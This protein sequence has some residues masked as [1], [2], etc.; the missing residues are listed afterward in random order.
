[1]QARGV[2]EFFLRQPRAM[3]ELAQN[4]PKVLPGWLAASVHTANGL[5]PTTISLHAYSLPEREDESDGI[6]NLLGVR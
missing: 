6:D 4:R 5:P 3:S 1:M 2:F